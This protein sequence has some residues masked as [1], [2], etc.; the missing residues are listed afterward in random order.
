M[1]DIKTGDVPSWC[2]IQIAF[3]ELILDDG[4]YTRYGVGLGKDPYE[5]KLFSDPLDRQKALTLLSAYRIRK[6][7]RG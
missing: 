2:G 3:Y 7:Y 5:L 6:E 4:P 1:I